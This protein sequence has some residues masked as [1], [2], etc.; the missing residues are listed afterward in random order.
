MSVQK[1]YTL[2]I[3]YERDDAGYEGKRRG[4]DA[5]F[6][7]YTTPELSESDAAYEELQKI[8]VKKLEQVCPISQG[9]VSAHLS[10]DGVVET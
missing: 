3:T 2:V 1:T 9:I 4:E 10:D 6:E 5:E 8:V 7:D